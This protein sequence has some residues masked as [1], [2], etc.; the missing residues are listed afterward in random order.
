MVE[1]MSISVQIMWIAVS[2]ITLNVTLSSM[3]TSATAICVLHL[4]CRRNV[5]LVSRVFHF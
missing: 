1:C 4:H 2:T 5:S 3:E